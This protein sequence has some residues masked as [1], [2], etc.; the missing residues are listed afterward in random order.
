MTL[1]ELPNYVSKL[2]E[3]IFIVGFDKILLAEHRKT[4]I[5]CKEAAR[6]LE[7]TPATY[8]HYLHGQTICSIKIL[9]KFC[10]L[11]NI[12]LFDRIGG[13]APYNPLAPRFPV[14]PSLGFG[15]AVPPLG[16]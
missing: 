2:N 9:K 6:R 16:A 13:F 7:T 12:N 11:Y 15:L 4:G 14:K 1:I 10:K 5:T 3:K 8:S